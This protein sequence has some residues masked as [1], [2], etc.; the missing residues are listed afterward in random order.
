MGT[1]QTA[2]RENIHRIK[3]VANIGEI[4]GEHVNLQRAGANLKGLCPF[5]AENTPS[6]MVSP[7]RN[8]FHCFGCGAGGDV[9]TFLMRYHQL[10]FP[11]ALR[12]LAERYHI[13]LTENT[14]S[15][16]QR[17]QSRQRETIY[18][19][20]TH[21][22][23]LYHHHLLNAPAA[24]PAREYLAHRGV[25]PEIIKRFQ[26]GYAPASWDFLFNHS[27]K[28]GFAPEIV[29]Q[30]G[31]LIARKSEGP[32]ADQGESQGGDQ[33]DQGVG[34]GAGRGADQGVN[35]KGGRDKSRTEG[36]A[37]TTRGYYDR[38]RHRIMFPIID[39]TGRISGF[40]GRILGEGTPKY[41]N[42]PE[43]PVFNKSRTLFGLYQ[44]REFI[45]KAKKC[46]VVEGN[47]DLLA[48]ASRGVVEV[49]APLGTALST[50]QLRIL[51]GYVDEVVLLF[52]G[53]AAGL[54]AAMGTIPRFLAAKLTGRVAI[55]PDTHDPDSLI[56]AYGRRGIDELVALAQSL[57]EFAFAKLAE[58][59]GLGVD[60][61]N[62]IIA[63]LTPIIHA[64][65]DQLLLRTRFIAHFSEKL[66]ISAE[67]FCYS[68][69]HR[70][71][72]QRRPSATAPPE[73]SLKLTA[74]EEKLLT[75]LF[76]NGSYLAE[77][78][79]ADLQDFITTPAAQALM[80]LL[81]RLNASEV[82]FIQAPENLLHH[83]DDRLKSLVARLLISSDSIYP[84]QYREESARQL[85]AWLRRHQRKKSADLLNRE[86]NVAYQGG[87]QQRL[88]TLM[89]QKQERQI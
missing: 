57:P 49:V 12:Q 34:Q 65:D 10:S 1:N 68:I 81:T 2:G 46:L 86:I 26:L 30:A 33:E 66:G 13:P 61:K 14:I 50:D 85:I 6:F 16:Q 88:M 45:R 18:Q 64:L 71:Q 77:F 47:F 43:T 32:T 23:T 20:N 67:Q 44:H 74:N 75:F 78:I 11:E 21:A 76:L 89:K 5:H 84:E 39:L 15:P 40:G 31:L 7:E 37:I 17:E 82:D 48:L 8:S 52:D 72:P 4:I 3:D 83:A 28:A 35:Q 27:K 24:R 22:A 56:R 51:R 38:F 60:G 9:F 79:A 87:D 54:R 70:P 42:T 55:L 36:S 25:P 59:H 19:I 63:E 53:D 58:Q 62:R 73:K 29:A 69:A 80:N 41:L